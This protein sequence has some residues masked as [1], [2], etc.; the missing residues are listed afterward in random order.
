MTCQQA[1]NIL[2]AISFSEDRLE[3]LQYIKRYVFLIFFYISY[4]Y[5]NFLMHRVLTD[6]NTQEGIDNIINTF[7][8]DDH[9]SVAIRILSSV[10]LV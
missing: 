2:A 1:R 4:I 5:L 9:K 8:Y 6:A 3:A 10:S 7:T